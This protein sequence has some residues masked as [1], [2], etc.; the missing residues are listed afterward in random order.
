MVQLF[1]LSTILEIKNHVRSIIGHCRG[2]QEKLCQSLKDQFFLKDSD[3]ITKKSFFE[4]IERPKKDLLAI[5]LRE[6]KK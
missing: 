2:S 5:N 6:F 1:E 4:W 3:K